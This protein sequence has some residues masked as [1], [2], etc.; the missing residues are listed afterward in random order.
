MKEAEEE[1]CETIGTDSDVEE[2]NKEEVRNVLKELAGLKQREA[3]CYDRLAKAVPDMQENEVVI[4]AEKVRRTELPQCVYQM[5]QN[6]E[7]QRLQGCAGSWGASI[8]YVQVSPSGDSA[9]VDPRA[10]HEL[11]CWEDQDL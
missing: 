10:L 8:Q 3:E 11:R 9:C 5:N 1:D 7:S 2:I 6:W 4:V